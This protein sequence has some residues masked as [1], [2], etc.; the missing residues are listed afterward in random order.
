[1]IKYVVQVRDNYDYK[2]IQMDV[3]QVS[4]H[5]GGVGYTLD[6]ASYDAHAAAQRVAGSQGYYRTNRLWKVPCQFRGRNVIIPDNIIF[7]TRE[8]AALAALQLVEEKIRMNILQK[9]KDMQKL[10]DEIRALGSKQVDAKGKFHNCS[11]MDMKK[12]AKKKP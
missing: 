7:D 11:T 2:I 8:D 10:D 9:K 1:M 5:T 12:T 6:R 4:T 3:I